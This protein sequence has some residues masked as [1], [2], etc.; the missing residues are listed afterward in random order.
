M[1]GILHLV[2]NLLSG[3]TLGIILVIIYFLVKKDELSE[4]ERQTCFEI[5]NFNLSFIVYSFVAACTIVLIIGVV[6]FPLVLVIWLVL[7]IK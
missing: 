2:G 4:L 1:L 3:G 7:M 5:I 6:L